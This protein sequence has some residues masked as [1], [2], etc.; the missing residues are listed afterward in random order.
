MQKHV[1]VVEDDNDILE[2]LKLYLEASEFLVSVAYDGV[3]ALNILKNEKID[4]L[5]ADIMMPRMN[6]YE[7]IKSVRVNSNIPIIIISAKNMDSD[8]ILG[9]DI[10][11]DAYVTK[12]FNP[13]EVVA[14]VKALL[15]RYN[16]L[17]SNSKIN[18]V[19]NIG[20]LSLYLSKCILKKNKKVVPLTSTEIK[21][22]A[23]MLKSPGKVFTKQQIYECISGEFYEC[24]DNTMMVHISN[25]RGKIEDNPSKPKYIKTV[26]GLGYKFE[27][28]EEI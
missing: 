11:A 15:R 10:G 17:S 16:E 14:Y 8:K 22:I 20:D 27:N 2:L 28:K 25:I 24:D 13:L 18:D 6:G 9:L 23:M 26:R 4:L 1:L 3:E 21:I 19:I 5:I 12:P 7:L